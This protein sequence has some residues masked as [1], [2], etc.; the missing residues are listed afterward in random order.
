MG[1]YQGAKLPRDLLQARGRFEAWRSRCQGRGRIPQELWKL[2]VQLAGRHGVSRTAS[3][4][5]LDYDSLKKRAEAVGSEPRSG[6]PAFVE[7]PSPVPAGKQCLFELDNRSGVTLRVQL[8]G[9]DTADLEVLA[10]HLG[11]AD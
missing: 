4:L 3:V 1:A 2:A 9:Y 8:L 5:R 11:T 6:L 7:L 10:R